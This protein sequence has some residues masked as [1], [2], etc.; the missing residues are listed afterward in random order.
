MLLAD[1]AVQSFDPQEGHSRILRS[2]VLVLGFLTSEV[3]FKHPSRDVIG[4]LG[5]SL[6]L[7]MCTS[8]CMGLLAQGISTSSTGP[9]CNGSLCGLCEFAE[10]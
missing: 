9:S 3:T 6:R 4:P 5:M 1:D 8:I 7:P 2:S 10:G